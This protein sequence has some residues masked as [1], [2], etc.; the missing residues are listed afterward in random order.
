M[1]NLITENKHFFILIIILFI[2]LVLRLKNINFYSF[3]YDELFSVDFSYPSRTFNQMIQL[4]VEDVHPPFYQILLWLWFKVFGVSEFIARSLSV[5]IGILTIIASYVLAKEFY[6]K[7]ISLT[8]AFIFS[9]NFFLIWYSQEARSYQLTILLSILSYLYFYRTLIY[10]D[11]KNL[12]L[13]WLV[14][15]AWMYTHY[16]S[17]F[18]ISTQ[19][20]FA[21]IFLIFFTK[22]KKKLIK[23]ISI[24]A[25]IF[26]ISLLPLLPYII[27]IVNNDTFYFL[28]KP[29]SLYFLTH[30]HYYFGYGGIF[31]VLFSF[32]ISIYFIFKNKL[33]KKEK[34]FLSMFF[35]WLIFGYLILYIKSTYSFSLVQ[36]RY[37]IV[38]IPPIVILSLFGISKLH[39]FLQIIL[40][41]IFI[42]FS[43]KVLFLDVPENYRQNHRDILKYVSNNKQI[44]I[45]E[46]VLGNGHNGNN[47]NHFQVYANML[48]LKLNIIDDTIFKKHYLNNLLPDCFYLIYTFDGISI[49]SL[50]DIF[51]YEKIVLNNS[52][53]VKEKKKYFRAQAVLISKDKHCENIK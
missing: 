34:I 45:Y 1:K 28:K 10:N 50:E 48:K 49:N 18:I 41:L 53:S 33:E 20:I 29:S 35:T 16:F 5:C 52:Y 14:T 4:T 22:D 43:Y 51:K 38:M 36:L 30:I 24:S 21:I 11:N 9:T 19:I 17:F 39:K 47:T 37:T 8:I 40:L 15:I 26:F 25:V 42:V 31:F 23:I 46:L 44:P 3:W 13:F 7:K 2:G 6:D 12:F 32:L 27:N